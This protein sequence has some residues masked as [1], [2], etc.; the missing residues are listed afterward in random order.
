MS[1][2]QHTKSF[3]NPS[4]AAGSEVAVVHLVEAAFQGEVGHR[5]ALD[6]LGVVA[7]QD[8]EAVGL[9]YLAEE[10]QAGHAS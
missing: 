4:T 10:E 6:R 3:I 9:A 7:F 2:K 1:S 8:E 5:Q